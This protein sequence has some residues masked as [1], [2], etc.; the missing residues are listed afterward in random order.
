MFLGVFVFFGAAGSL[1]DIYGRRVVMLSGALG[2]SVYCPIHLYITSTYYNMYLSTVSNTVFGIL[3]SLLGAPANAFFV[4]SVPPAARLTTL[5]LGYNIAQPI[6]GGMAPAFA[7]ITF[8]AGGPVMPAIVVVVFGM[9]SF[10]G[11]WLS[12]M[13]ELDQAFWRT[14][15]GNRVEEGKNLLI[16]GVELSSSSN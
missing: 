7:T 14:L 2:I 9:L 12:P 4:E 8:D 15:K 6:A 16:E 10:V 3:L 11:V 13:S 1:S 5:A